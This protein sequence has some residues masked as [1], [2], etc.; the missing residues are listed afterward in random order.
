[1]LDLNYITHKQVGRKRKKVFATK[2]LYQ[3]QLTALKE[4]GKRMSRQLTVQEFLA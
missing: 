1:M 4:K 3:N 2:I